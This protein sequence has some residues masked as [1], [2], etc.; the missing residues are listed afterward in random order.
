MSSTLLSIAL[1]IAILG[2][3]ALITHLFAR[4]MYLTCPRC[5]TLNAR[6]RTMCNRR[7]DLAPSFHP[8]ATGV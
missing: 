1:V 6:R 5:R 3:S 2:A 8:V 4:A 7:G